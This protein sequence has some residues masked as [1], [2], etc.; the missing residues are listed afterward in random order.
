MLDA[1]CGM[2]DAGCGMRDAGCGPASDSESGAA[3]GRRVCDARG[4]TT[5]PD[6]HGLRAGQRPAQRSG[7]GRVGSQ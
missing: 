1:G 6:R 5:P 4:Q 3:R 2:R 7:G